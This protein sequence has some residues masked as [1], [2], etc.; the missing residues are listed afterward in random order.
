MPV[1]PHSSSIHPDPQ[2]PHPPPPSP[3]SLPLRVVTPT[4]TGGS[5][6]ICTAVAFNRSG[7]LGGN[8]L[9]DP[10]YYGYQVGWE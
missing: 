9:L 7:T 5:R 3:R 1:P 10:Q 2:G 6:L 4:R 8:V